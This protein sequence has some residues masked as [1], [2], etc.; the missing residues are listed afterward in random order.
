MRLRARALGF[1][2]RHGSVDIGAVGGTRTSA[3][4]WAS[5]LI[6]CSSRAARA[7]TCAAPRACSTACSTAAAARAAAAASAARAAAAVDISAESA[8]ANGPGDPLSGLASEVGLAPLLIAAG[9]EAPFEKSGA[10][11]EAEKARGEKDGEDGSSSEEDGVE[12]DPI[13][14]R[15]ALKQQARRIVQKKSNKAKHTKR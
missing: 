8:L 3:L 12:L 6:R 14:D 5:R 4:R 11:E 2:G 10:K 15:E 7:S 13:L 9:G 1:G